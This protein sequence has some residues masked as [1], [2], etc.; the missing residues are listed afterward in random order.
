M[1]RSISGEE[2][3]EYD[4]A[5]S[6]S[7]ITSEPC[8]TVEH[9]AIVYEKYSE[10]AG[11]VLEIRQYFHTPKP[12]APMEVV[13]QVEASTVSFVDTLIRRN[14][15]YKSVRLPI[16]PGFDVVG[17][18]VSVGEKVEDRNLFKVGD[19][20]AALIKRGGNA[21]YANVHSD[22]LVKVPGGIDAAEAACV[23]HTYTSAYQ[24]LRCARN[25]LT[26]SGAKVLVTGGNSPMGEAVVELSKKAGAEA[27]YAT[28]DERHHQHLKSLG[29]ICLPFECEEWLPAV[30][31]QMDVVIDS[32]CQDSYAS[33]QAALNESGRLVCTGMSAIVSGDTSAASAFLGTSAVAMWASLS[34][35]YL[36]KQTCSYDVWSSFKSNPDVFKRDLEYLLRLLR[37]RE[38]QPNVQERIGLEE[39]AN[40][41]YRL[42][43]GQENGCIVCTPWKK[44]MR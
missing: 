12:R 43:R 1:S 11:D 4:N 22:R 29:A 25:S 42:E 21:C 8:R 26:L 32:L 40:A 33:P 9:A 37:K 5:L 10:Y 35:S 28:A 23:T 24:A 34:S 16:T 39:V 38:I 3:H 19:R 44:I 18:I 13:I 27:V 36:M 14:N 15:W 20:V 17:T 30:K 41:H 6:S 2:S 31:G 7:P